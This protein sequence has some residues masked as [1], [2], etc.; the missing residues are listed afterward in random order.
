MSRTATVRLWLLLALL[1]SVTLALYQVGRSGMMGAGYFNGHS[2]QGSTW[3]LRDP[4]GR[5]D[6]A[7]A[8]RAWEAGRFHHG[9][10]EDLVFGYTRDAIWLTTVVANP[11]DA[12][13][14]YYLEVGPP[15]LE[16]VR[17][18][19]Q[20]ADGR[21]VSYESGIRV[22][23]LRRVVPTRLLVVPVTLA[24]HAE[25]R[26]FVRVSSRNSMLV[27]L[28]LWEP[29]RLL[30]AA[31]HMDLLNGLQFGALLLFA[32]YAFAAAAVGR[33]R[34]YFYFGVTLFCYAA[35]DIAILQYGYQ[36]L[37]PDMP[38][39]SLRSPGVVLGVAVFGLGM[40]V[41]V[42][43]DTVAL[44]PRWNLV[45]RGVATFGLL[46]VPGM[47]LGDYRWW[48][49]VLNYA[50][51]LQLLV[52][53]SATLQAVFLG[54]RGALLLLAAFV[55]LWFTSL[56]RVAQILGWFPP[57]IL[58]EYSQGWSMVAGGLLLAM[59]QVDRVRR[60]DEEREEAR[61]ALVRAQ[62]TA[63]EQAEQAVAERTRE[64]VQA[65][66]AAEAS[67]RAKS[68]F[69]A[70]LSHELR[71]PLHSILGYS[72][73]LRAEAADAEAQ[74]RLDAIH[75]SGVHLLNLIDGLLD[76]ARGEAGRLQLELKPLRLRPFLE[77]V[78]EETRELAAQQGMVLVAEYDP[79]LPE[80]LRLDG[81]RLRQVLINLIANACRHSRG[82]RIVLAASVLAPA[83]PGLVRVALAV[84]DDGVGIAAADRERVF[85]PFEQGGEGAASRGL[86]L[87]LAI[88]RQLVL[89]MGGEIE[90]E[91]VARGASFRIVLDAE[92]IEL[93]AALPE[94]SPAPA[95]Y[96]G[97]RRR[98]LVVDDEADSREVL[99]G[100][101]LA[102][103]FA[104]E[105][106]DSAAAALEILAHDAVDLVL[107]DQRMPGM[108]GPA[109]LQAARARGCRQPFLLVS[110]LVGEATAAQG[111]GFA[112]TLVKPL[113]AER[114][115]A[116]V[117]RTLGLAWLQ[118]LRP[119]PAAA[120]AEWVRPSAAL[121]EELR[122]AA[123]QGRISDI[124]DWVAHVR[125][126]EPAAAGFA[127]DVMVAV[128]RLD[129]AGILAMT[130]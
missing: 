71:T 66:D 117:S 11:G 93:P 53:I 49:Q 5:M 64:L 86:G 130:R 76:Y 70:Q 111:E 52:T 1:L 126:V 101:L 44:L 73:L 107:S 97:P 19:L 106:A 77:S 68:A 67:S 45:L 27:Q 16:D 6:A 22:P 109:L 13:A 122:V 8:A 108:D 51:L 129:L 120:T 21:T 20:Q 123:E 65:R 75:R 116:A 127:D 88:A 10:P 113:E 90:L 69:L 23:L 42:M 80:S 72:S 17:I 112:A 84:R 100:M 37:W 128:R 58:A 102:M 24:P 4:G 3:I 25:Q 89:L 43:L 110:A 29:A 57:N 85:K 55:L 26:V 2:L 33:S 114:L 98:V 38:D 78:L 115:A 9:A 74:R 119:A 35:Y 83:R 87:G 34:A 81:T 59:N 7:A 41:A 18:H 82:S 118:P 39:W 96:A 54:S 31:R 28:R 63:R 61:R 60:L 15:R 48:V 124:E 121:L 40:L 47:L 14:D 91:A 30:E 56:L 12:P 104:V 50:A 62:V 103:G 46:L 92:L 95:R 99:A 32:L 125:E 94:R 79:A 105:T 36:Y